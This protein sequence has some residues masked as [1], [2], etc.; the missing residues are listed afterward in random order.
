MPP[1]T[2]SPRRFPSASR[3]L[4]A[5]CC[6]VAV[7]LV[8]VGNGAAVTKQDV[9]SAT[10][11]VQRILGKVQDQRDALAALQQKLVA[12][13]NTLDEALNELDVTTAH[14]LNTKQQL[15]RATKLH[16]DT[17]AQLNERAVQAFMGGGGQ[18][19]EFIVGSSSLS[20]LSDRIEFMDALAQGDADLA[21]TVQNTQNELD[22]R[23][24][25]LQDLQNQQKDAVAKAT[26]AQAA[27]TQN[28]QEQ[29]ASVNRITSLL[30]AAENYKKKVSKAYQAELAAAAQSQG[31]YGSGHG[32]VAVPPG[33][34]HAL[35]VCPVDGPRS[36][37]DGFGAPRYFGGYHLH[38]GIDMLSPNGTPIVAP[39]DG[40]AS[41]SYNSAGGDTV[42]VQ[43]AIGT[44]YNAHLSRY[45]SLSN[46]TVHTGDIIGY[47]GDSGDA[48][49]IYH[50]HFEF[51]PN[52]MP[53]SWPASPYGY[54]IIE[55][56]VDPYPLLV[57]ACG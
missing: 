10:A 46:G 43:G 23:A 19:F 12:T 33:Y 31:P 56:A 54:S 35:Q 16:D 1:M 53:S 44:V 40:T 55:D 27:V 34:E 39:F 48:A 5:T 7:L 22:L 8:P 3:Y 2:S 29:Q 30:A 52:V 41:T 17:I 36:F 24:S 49:P 32:A 37:G 4:A 28:F 42:S 38:K 6:L 14:L 11:H 20:D 18:D 26:A 51:H 9:S 25:Q 45:S 21:Q 57:A 15:A 50:D 13:T 47:V